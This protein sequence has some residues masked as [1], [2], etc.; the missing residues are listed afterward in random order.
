MSRRA[1][2][3]AYEQQMTSISLQER[4]K[5]DIFAEFQPRIL[6][7]A[8]RLASKIPSNIPLAM[9]DLV[10]YGAI[11]LLEAIERFEPSRNNQFNTFADFRIRGAMKDAI[12]SF[13][14]MSRHRRDQEKDIRNTEEVLHRELGRR[15]LPS[16]VAQEMNISLSEYFHLKNNTVNVI[17]SSVTIS[18]STREEK[19]LVELLEDNGINPLDVLLD[20]EFRAGVREAIDQLEERQKQCIL[21]YYGRNLNLTEVAKVFEITPSRVSQILSKARAQL[22]STLRQ[23]AQEAGYDVGE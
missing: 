12:R 1:G 16:E 21:L 3:R 23:I 19:V 6:S 7:I 9:E 20:E 14:T 8:R 18:D 2:L 10:S 11:G 13:D 17:E 4:S 15:P 22:L 5:E